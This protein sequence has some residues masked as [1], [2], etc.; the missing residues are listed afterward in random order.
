MGLIVS[1]VGAKVM[2]EGRV[3]RDDGGNV[4]SVSSIGNGFAANWSTDIVS[5]HQLQPTI[6]QR[7]TTQPP[8]Q[9]TRTQLQSD[10]D[11]ADHTQDALGYKVVLQ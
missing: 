1:V 3:V 2:V 7:P 6:I 5:S 11:I 8:Q 10:Y 4:V 9:A